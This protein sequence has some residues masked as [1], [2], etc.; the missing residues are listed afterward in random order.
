MNGLTIMTNKDISR[1]D[2]DNRQ[3][4]QL[5]QTTEKIAGVLDK[6]LKAHLKVLRPLFLPRKLLGAYIKSAVME[7]TPGSDKAFA[8]LQEMF[9]SIREK[10]FGPPQKLHPPLPNISNHL[11]AVPFEY[12]LPME[13]AGEKSVAVTS[14]TRWVLSYQSECPFSRLR[15]MAAGQE[16]PRPDD[17]RQSL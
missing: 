2:L 15:A 16:P 17:A 6:R 7:E 5:R 3:F 8:E 14:P 4:M 1:K 11:Q 9:A 13:G 12:T 10:S